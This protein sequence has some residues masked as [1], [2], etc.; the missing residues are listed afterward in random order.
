MLNNALI[1]FL[2]GPRGSGKSTVGALVARNLDLPFYDT[3]DILME[4]TGRSIAAIVGSDGWEAFRA[5]ESR[6]LARAVALAGASGEIRRSGL[7]GKGGVI[8]TGGGII[9]APANRELMRAS[10]TVVHLAAPAGHLHS[11]LRDRR[12]ACRRPPLSHDETLEEE[13]FRTLQEREPMYRQ[14]AHH[15]IDATASPAAAAR[16]IISLLGATGKESL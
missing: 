3:D 11:R 10:G 6:T 5:L 2:I 15:R 9:L 8:A 7:A 4:Q 13:I 12:D 16:R 14:T 1:L